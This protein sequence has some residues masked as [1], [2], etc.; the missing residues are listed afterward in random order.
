MKF[1]LGYV[2]ENVQAVTG[3]RSDAVL[4]YN[5]KKKQKVDEMQAVMMECIASGKSV[6]ECAQERCK[7]KSKNLP[8]RV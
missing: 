6:E 5:V 7:F 4:A 1:E 2:K 8:Q 3:H